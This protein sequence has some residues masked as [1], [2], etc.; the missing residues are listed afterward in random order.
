MRLNGDDYFTYYEEPDDLKKTLKAHMQ[1]HAYRYRHYLAYDALLVCLGL[2]E[3]ADK[4]ARARIDAHYTFLGRYLHPTHDA[5]RSLHSNNNVHESITR[6]GMSQPYDP[7]ASLL[8][9]MYVMHLLADTL[10]TVAGFLENAPDYYI[11]DPG[12][13]SIREA[14][15]AA[16]SRFSY[17]WLIYNKPTDYDKFNYAI[18]H[19]SDED[20]NKYGGY[21]MVPDKL[22][23]FNQ[24]I[25]GQFQGAL[26]SWSNSRCG[27]Y[28][29]PILG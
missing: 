29:S 22:I 6:S 26:G 1:E 27:K 19:V 21:M 10:D 28:T 25:Y 5:A 7:K 24:H 14:T 12:T 8:A 23:P 13:S 9:V 17:F 4:K 15:S 11:K 3:M 16:R 2:N 18:H 20:L